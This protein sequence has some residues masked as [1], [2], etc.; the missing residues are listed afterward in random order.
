VFAS[1][2]DTDVPVE[3][4]CLLAATLEADFE[5][6][7]GASHVGPLLGRSAARTAERVGEWLQHRDI[8]TEAN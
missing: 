6:V 8:A 2:H 5:Q 3:S 4:S 7:A 1:E